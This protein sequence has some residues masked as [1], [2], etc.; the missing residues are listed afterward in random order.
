MTGDLDLPP[1]PPLPPDVRQRALRTVLRSM[2]GPAPSPTPRVRIQAR[3]WPFLAA[4][5]AV[6]T[7]LLASVVAVGFSGGAPELRPAVP[8]PTSGDEQSLPADPELRRCAAAVA[9]AGKSDQY[10]PFDQWR[11]TDTLIDSPGG[12]RAIAIDDG[13]AC[14]LG[15]SEV[16]V[17]S[18]QGQVIGPVAAVRL[19]PALAVLLNPRRLPVRSALVPADLGTAKTD[20]VQLVEY[21]VPFESGAHV[22]VVAGDYDG[23]LPDVGPNL[24]TVQDRPSTS[25]APKP[26]QQPEEALATCLDGWLPWES[27]RTLPWK[28]VLVHSVEGKATAMVGRDDAG[29]AG[30]CYLTGSGPYFMGGA[31]QGRPDAYVVASVDDPAGTQMVLVAVPDSVQRV[32]VHRADRTGATCDRMYEFALCDR[33]GPDSSIY[34]FESRDGSG[35]GTLVPR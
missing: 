34:T 21:G 22:R 20:P 15:P 26:G 19:A 27:T 32:E 9:V 23:P 35:V 13:F 5:A 2:D 1:A 4:A 8:A 31:V 25:Y 6:V 18:P 7:V 3:R 16:R 24:V 33:A 10:R 12:E 28:L 30:F 29:Y 14:F 17:S 11:I